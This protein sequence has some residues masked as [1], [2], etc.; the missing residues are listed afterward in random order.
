[1]CARTSAFSS[2][3]LSLCSITSGAIQQGCTEGHTHAHKTTRSNGEQG[4][5]E[6]LQPQPPDPLRQN[7]AHVAG[8]RPPARTY[9]SRES[10]SRLLSVAV[11]HERP[12]DAEVGE[13]YVAG[14]GDEDVAGLE[15]AV[16][17]AVLV[18]VEQSVEHLAQDGR[19]HGFVL[20]AH[21][22]E[23]LHDVRAATRLEQRHHQPEVLLH[24]ER[25]QDTDHVR[26]VHQRLDQDL[27]S[28]L[29]PVRAG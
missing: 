6:S 5:H 21:G 10:S 27:A 15:V 9:R 25:R 2:Y 20:D 11:L 19:H 29:F 12:R 4:K 17:A 1:M 22:V 28:D 18:E 8:A 23:R 16:E 7:A 24:H 13:L 3:P 14:G 26:V